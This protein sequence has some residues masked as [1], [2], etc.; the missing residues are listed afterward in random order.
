MISIEMSCIFSLAKSEKKKNF[1]LSLLVVYSPG[2][3]L[4]FI[5]FFLFRLKSF[6]S[7]K[8]KKRIT[9]KTFTSMARHLRVYTFCGRFGTFAGYEN[10]Q[11]GINHHNLCLYT[12]AVL[13]TTRDV[14]LNAYIFPIMCH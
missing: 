1:F 5:F 14:Y 12:A 3:N 2:V 4:K 13:I 6:E 11:Y 8:E 9:R 10:R 7:F